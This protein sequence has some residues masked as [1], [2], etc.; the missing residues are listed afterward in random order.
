MPGLVLHERICEGCV[1]R[2]TELSLYLTDM[3]VQNYV[4]YFLF[5][6]LLF[7]VH[8]KH[9]AHRHFINRSPSASSEG[10]TFEISSEF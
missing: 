4:K 5:L 7:R 2:E 1:V 10:E 3:E 9:R 8:F 6:G